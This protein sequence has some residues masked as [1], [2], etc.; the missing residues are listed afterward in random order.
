MLEIAAVVSAI[1]RDWA[2][3]AIILLMLV[4]N[5]LIGFHEERKAKQS[6]DALK[7][8]MTATVPT[9][10]DGAMVILPVAELVPG[11]VIFLRG[12]NIVP[13]DCEWLEGDPMLVDTAC[14]T[15]E[16]LPR[17]VPR[18]DREGEPPGAGRILLSG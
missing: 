15:G 10:R 7:A 11:D 3:F 6:L 14:L 17:K 5:G 18:P 2:D 4:V 13:A 1:T 12:G 8:Q 16:P 9:K